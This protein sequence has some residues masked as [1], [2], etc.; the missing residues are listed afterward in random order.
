MG[1][2]GHPGMHYIGTWSGDVVRNT[3]IVQVVEQARRKTDSVDRTLG[4]PSRQTPNGRDAYERVEECD[5][6]H[7]M[8]DVEADNLA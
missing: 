5:D 1:V 4:T 6:P 7:A 8:I 3:S 2:A